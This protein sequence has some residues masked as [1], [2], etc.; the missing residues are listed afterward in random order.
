MVLFPHFT[1]I[2]S[3]AV[4]VVILSLRPLTLVYKLLLSNTH[5]FLCQLE[6]RLANR[7]TLLQASLDNHLDRLVKDLEEK[8]RNRNLEPSKNITQVLPISHPSP[9]IPPLQNH[10]ALTPKEDSNVLGAR[11]AL[12]KDFPRNPPA[13]LAEFDNEGWLLVCDPELGHCGNHPLFWTKDKVAPTQIFEIENILTSLQ[14]IVKPTINA[15]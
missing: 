10:P 3:T 13:A 1:I 7:F 5:N 11:D 14:N 6:S 9:K 2:L 15:L 8:A 12:Q 4:I